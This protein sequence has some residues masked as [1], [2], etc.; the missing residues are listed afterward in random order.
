[1]TGIKGFPAR[2]AA[3]ALIGALSALS[4]A[5]PAGAAP[6]ASAPP[7]PS[8]PDFQGSA[9]K[10]HP[11]TPTR[12]PQNP[13]MGS[14]PFNNIHNDTWM[15]DAYRIPGPLGSNLTAS[16]DAKGASLCGSLTFDTRGRILSV[17]PSA[18]A[19]PQARIIDPATLATVD[20][21]DLPQAPD[22]PNTPI[23]QNFTGGGYF[24]LDNR[25]RMWIPTKTDHI[26]VLGES[27]DGQTLVKKRDYDLTGVLDE[28]TERITSALPDFSGRIWFVSKK[29]GKVG[30]L[31]RKTRTIRVKTMG[32][33]I[34]N[35]FAV[36]RRGVYIV[37]DKR[38]Y[39]F[40]AG[41]HGRPVIA[42]KAGYKNSGIVKPS[43]VDAGSGT[44]PTLMS[45]GYVAITDN[46]EPMH[47]VVY[48]RARHLHRGERRKVCEVPVFPKK[49]GATENTLLTAGRSLIVENNYGYQDPFGPNTGA[50][51]EPGFARVDVKRNGRGCKK[52]WTNHD[53]RAPTRRAEALDQDRPDLHLHPAAGPERLRGLL[54][55]GAAILQR[56]DRLAEVRRLGSAL[57]Q[58]LRRPR[59]RPGR[60]RLPR[61]DRRHHRPAR[62][63]QLTRRRA[64]PTAETAI[65]SHS[66]RKLR[67][68]RPW[69]SWA[70]IGD[71][72]GRVALHSAACQRPPA[73][74]PGPASPVQ[75]EPERPCVAEPACERVFSWARAGRQHTQIEERKA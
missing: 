8:L 10:A 4:A 66:E 49:A 51:T 24:F 39:R 19:P 57:Q 23:Y 72:R 40:D 18:A 16:S 12:A 3:I 20:T 2:F 43:Q 35:S 65:S 44:T 62:R 34:E 58:Q 68:R 67:S 46:A 50:V 21:F 75:V 55:G 61:R 56:Q 59:A 1:M 54:L 31:D 33:E 25:D 9:V 11:V 42:W 17:C 53:L 69:T 27:A 15:T 63:E 29:N 52:V 64:N 45:H 30:T 7:P 60:H 5:A 22:P 70:G 48:R 32:D 38:M 73:G 26:F 47:V 28:D 71:G 13:F 41:R 37:T 74:P 14:N 6:I 36:G